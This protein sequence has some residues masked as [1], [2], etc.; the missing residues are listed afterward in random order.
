MSTRLLLRA[1]CGVAAALALLA[2]GCGGSDDASPSAASQTTS[3]A[4]GQSSETYR[5]QLTNIVSGPDAARRLY[6]DAPPGT[7]AT[8]VSARRLARSSRSA[9]QEIEQLTP[10]AGLTDLN[11][12]LAKKY[13]RWAAALD[14]EIVRKPVSTARIGDVV[15][16]YG[17]AA[18][19]VYEQILIAP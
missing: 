15:R 10:E 1:L 16:D 9:A 3:V 7:L 11:A 18:D 17:Q 5:D 4:A 14:R 13:R 2:A 6:Y 19:D 8:L 12:D